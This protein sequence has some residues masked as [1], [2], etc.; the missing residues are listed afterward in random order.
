MLELVNI[1]NISCDTE[2]VLGGK[3]ENLHRFL[4]RHNLAGIEFTLYGQWDRLMPPADTVQGV[5]LPFWPDWLD[6]WRQDWP[7]L[8]QSFGT[9]EMV[10]QYYSAATKEAWLQQWRQNISRAVGAEAK[11]VVFHVC[12]NRSR[13]M[14]NRR[15]SYDNQQVVTASIE[16]LNELVDEL[17]DECWLLLENLW[18][19]GLTMQQPELCQQLVEGIKHPRTGFMLDTGHLMNT[20]WDLQNQLDGV[21][22]VE[23]I[24]KGLGEM[25]HFI[26]GMH[27]HQSLSGLFVRTKAAE[28]PE[29]LQQPLGWEESFQ[30]VSQV[31]QHQPFSIPEA[32]ELVEL[33]KPDFLVHEF[34]QQDMADWEQKVAVQRSALGY[35]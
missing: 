17:P 3:P 35:L 16:L 6:F 4:A 22:Y 29:P 34:I 8:L 19:P 30:Y 31:D 32:R 13:E 11:Y 26:K 12:S 33:I 15:F 9:R 24:V 23:Q 18:W 28:N 7:E 25:R 1:S 27:L 14:I 2:G 5:H 21:E 20:N 10:E